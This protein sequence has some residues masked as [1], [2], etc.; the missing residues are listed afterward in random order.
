MKP[1]TRVTREWRCWSILTRKEYECWPLWHTP[2]QF[3]SMLTHHPPCSRSTQRGMRRTLRSHCLLAPAR[4]FAYCSPFSFENLI[5][6]IY[7][8]QAAEELNEAA[9]PLQYALGEDAGRALREE[10]R[11]FLVDYHRRRS[12]H[13]PC[14]LRYVPTSEVSC[15]I[16]DLESG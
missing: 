3:L 6:Q 12:N 10:V 5:H 7:T 8:F 4:F 11:A 2:F 14:P 1:K 16:S 15:V 13:H 9:R